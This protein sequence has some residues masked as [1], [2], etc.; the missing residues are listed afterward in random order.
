[1]VSVKT[2]RNTHEEILQVFTCD[3][4]NFE[5]TKSNF[6]FSFFFLKHFEPYFFPP[7]L[8][9]CNTLFTKTATTRD[10][11]WEKNR[12]LRTQTQRVGTCSAYGRS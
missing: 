2:N 8:F 3:H 1:M 7:K 6:G 12:L 5:E 9:V 4:N 11:I 10:S